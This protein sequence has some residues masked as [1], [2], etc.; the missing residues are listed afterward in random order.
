MLRR[1]YFALAQIGSESIPGST[2]ALSLVRELGP[3]LTALVVGGRVSASIAAELGTMKVTEQIDAMELLAIDPMRYLVAMT[4]LVL[5][6]TCAH[7][8]LQVGPLA[9][10][11]DPELGTG[12]V[13]PNNQGNATPYYNQGDSGSNPARDGVATA[14]ELVETSRLWARTAARVQPEWA[15]ELAEHLVKR[16]YSEP[17]WSTTRAAAMAHTFSVH[18]RSLW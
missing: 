3:V 6:A 4:G 15:E 2:V 5:A 7:G 11:V 18:A 1:R 8:Q 12:I 10:P 13:P 9:Q 16:S 17:H 14:A